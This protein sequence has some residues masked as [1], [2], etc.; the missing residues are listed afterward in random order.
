[1][2]NYYKSYQKQHYLENREYYL[3][4]SR[5]YKEKNREKI[6]AYKKKNRDENKEAIREYRKAWRLK[7]KES[8]AEKKRAYRLEYLKNPKNKLASTFRSQIKRALSGSY[9]SGTWKQLLGCSVEECKKYLE[10]KFKPGMTWEN[11][12]E[13]HIDHIRPIASFSMKTLPKAFH[14]KNLQPLW[15]LENL[16]KGDTWK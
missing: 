11:H 15:A 9:K 4:A 1:M 12:G 6:L 2:D 7:N 16:S 5:R 8:I 14:Y 10:S 3:E 13:W